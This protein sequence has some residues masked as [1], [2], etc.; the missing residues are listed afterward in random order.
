MDQDQ[1][2]YKSNEEIRPPLLTYHVDST[3]KAQVSILIWK[4]KGRYLQ[5]AQQ[6]SKITCSFFFFFFKPECLCVY[7]SIF[8]KHDFE[9][10]V[11][12]LEELS[13]RPHCSRD[14][15]DSPKWGLL[16][17]G[18]LP[19]TETKRSSAG[20]QLRSAAPSQQGLPRSWQSCPL[21]GQGP[22]HRAAA[23]ML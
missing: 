4:L 18:P 16:A 10:G 2:P 11:V 17:S 3:L 5:R 15:A 21:L 6:V 20:R 13:R 7:R 8:N 12:N 14:P 1:M 23:Q 9:G 22:A 19:I